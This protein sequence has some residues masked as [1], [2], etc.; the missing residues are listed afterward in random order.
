MKI[1]ER[2][3]CLEAEQGQ[4]EQELSTLQGNYYLG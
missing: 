4:A 1:D 3:K 2:L